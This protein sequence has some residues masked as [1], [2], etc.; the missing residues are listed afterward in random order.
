M[1]LIQTEAIVLGSQAL[2]DADRLITLLTLS[3]GKIKGVAKG[4]CRL[5]NRFG[6]ALEPFTHCNLSFIER[7]TGGLCQ[8]QQAEIVRSY[9]ELRE[10]L[11]TIFCG[12]HFLIWVRAFLAEGEA[13]P[14]CFELLRQFLSL[15]SEVRNVECL[16]RGFELRLLDLAGYRPRLD[17]CGRCGQALEKKQV[18]FSP[19]DGMAFC[20]S[21]CSPGDTILS[22]LSPATVASFHQLLVLLPS[23]VSRLH[24]SDVVRNELQ[25]MTRAYAKHLLGKELGMSRV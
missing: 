19:S 7:R 15:L 9:Q 22:P 8:I 23:K 2:G 24:L 10:D 5:R 3:H 4:A 13:R 16:A 1:S 17:L 6:G 18:Y 14:S 21:C 20:D 11:E 25:G 12:S